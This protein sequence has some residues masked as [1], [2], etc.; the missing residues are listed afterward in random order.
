M[1]TDDYGTYDRFIAFRAA[2]M[3]AIALA[4]GDAEYRA[5][6]IADPKK[7]LKTAFDYDFPFKI[8]L[9]VDVDNAKWEPITVA[10]WHVLRR[11]T[12]HMVLPPKP[13]DPAEQV[14]ALAAFN[15]THLTF[16]TDDK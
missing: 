3:Q 11:D 2:V 10:D 12:L 4:W 8:D 13:E 14:E 16:L 5:Q 7:A 9:G 1:K 6:L 15:A